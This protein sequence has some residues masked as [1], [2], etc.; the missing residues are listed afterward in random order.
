ML[1]RR[2]EPGGDQKRAELVAVQR[3]GMRLVIDPGTA[4]VGRRECSRSSS[5]TAYL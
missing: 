1:K 4:D 2:P 3:D 5:S